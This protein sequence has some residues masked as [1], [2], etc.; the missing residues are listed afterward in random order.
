[1]PA[2]FDTPS[3]VDRALVV[4]PSSLQRTVRVKV[5][6]APRHA[7]A[8]E[9]LVSA[10]TSSNT[11]SRRAVVTHSLVRRTIVVRRAPRRRQLAAVR[12]KPAPAPTPLPLVAPATESA[13]TAPPSPVMPDDVQVKGHEGNDQRDDHGD[14]HGEG[15]GNGRPHGHGHDERED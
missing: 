5:P 9:R 2:L 8:A 10:H 13:A 6:P 7:P 3:E 11:A 12:P 1:M 14:G 4:P 15:N